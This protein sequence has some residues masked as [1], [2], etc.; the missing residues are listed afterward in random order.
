MV[1]LLTKSKRMQKL[2]RH[3][4]TKEGFLKWKIGIKSSIFLKFRRT[5]KDRV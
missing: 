3:K 4:A 2:G 1:P 5:I